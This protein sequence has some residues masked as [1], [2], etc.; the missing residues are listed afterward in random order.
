M[1]KLFLGTSAL[2]HF[3]AELQR[4]INEIANASQDADVTDIG[5][6]F[7]ISGTYTPTRTLNVS[8]PTVANIAAVLATLLADL[9]AGGAKRNT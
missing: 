7:E 1:R 2:G 8:S 5:S 6:A 4:I 9:K 3:D